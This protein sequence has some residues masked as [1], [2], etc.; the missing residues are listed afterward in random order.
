MLSCYVFGRVYISQINFI[1]FD[2]AMNSSST[3]VTTSARAVGRF[4]K[5]TS[6]PIRSHHTGRSPH[7]PLKNLCSTEGNTFKMTFLPYRDTALRNF[8]MTTPQMAKQSFNVVWLRRFQTFS[9]F[10]SR[11]I[12]LGSVSGKNKLADGRRIE[13]LYNFN[14]AGIL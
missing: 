13:K 12:L 5:T 7:A 14:F 9:H 8:S 2:C 4:A 10:F 1:H 3:L 11:S 6:Y